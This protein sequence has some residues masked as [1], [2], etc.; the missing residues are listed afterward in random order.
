LLL[1]F[2]TDKTLIK[3]KQKKNPEDEA[4]SGCSLRKGY[5]KH[6]VAVA[7]AKAL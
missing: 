5:R 7:A 6:R 1:T 2:K 3:N 4:I